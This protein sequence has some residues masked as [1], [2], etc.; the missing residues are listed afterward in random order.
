VALWI[1]TSLILFD[2]QVKKNLKAIGAQLP[3][4]LDPTYKNGFMKWVKLVTNRRR[5]ALT[6][7]IFF[8][9]IEISWIIGIDLG[10]SKSVSW[11]F[12]TLVSTGFAVAI[13]HGIW[14]LYIVLFYSHYFKQ[15]ELNLFQDNPSG[16]VSLQILHRH[17]GELLLVLALIVTLGLPAGVFSSMFRVS[18]VI[19]SAAGIGI[20]L[21]IRL[22][23]LNFYTQLE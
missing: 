21:F 4:M 7:L 10:F 20:P 9:L 19:I 2:W 17:S 1:W 11:A 6:A 14:V 22:T 18:L 23:C 13:L 5:E 15:L 16:T 12:L 8:L 3:G